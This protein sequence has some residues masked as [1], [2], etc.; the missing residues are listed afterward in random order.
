M[1]VGCLFI[2]D[3]TPILNFSLKQFSGETAFY[4]SLFS[5]PIACG[6]AVAGVEG[7][8]TIPTEHS[9]PQTVLNDQ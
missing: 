5:K 7:G 2:L 1:V 3:C 4:F 6:A 8:R 9:A